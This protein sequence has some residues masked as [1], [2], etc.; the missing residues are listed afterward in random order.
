MF[1]LCVSKGHSSGSD[2]LIN[3]YTV[4]QLTANDGFVSS[5]IYSIIQDQQGFLWFG[6]AENGVMRYDGNKVRLFESNLG[7]AQGLSHNDAGNLMLDKDGNI[8]VGTWGGGANK[9]D[10]ATGKFQRFSNDPNNV[11]SLS[12]NRIQSLFHDST[13]TIW[14]G[15]YNRGLN[16]YLGDNAF[17][18]ILKKEDGE[19][20]GESTGLS[21]NRIWDIIDS[22]EAVSYTHLTLPTSDL[23]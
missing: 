14:L 9:Y 23:V 17:Q 12:S 19:E 22:D 21:H 11:T 8:W 18:R 1:F 5:E 13:G 10:P 2:E 20:E 4:D 16:K 3:E 6:T 15:T 7:E